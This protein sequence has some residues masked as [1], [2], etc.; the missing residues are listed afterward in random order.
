MLFLKRQLPLLI[1]FIFGMIGLLT[2][3]SPH[4][5]TE[6][7][8][9]ELVFW[10]RLVAA[11]ALLL[12]MYSLL[13]MHLG[14]VEKRAKG[15]GFSAVLLVGF[16]VTLGVGIYNEG[17]W[18]FGQRASHGM[19]NWIYDYIFKPA[20]ATMFSVLAFFIASAAYRTFRARTTM[21]ALLLIAALIVMVGQVPIGDMISS[22]LP[23]LSS[24][25]MEV[26]NAAVKR[27]IFM[28]VALGVVA[29]SLR[30]IFGVERAYLGGE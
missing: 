4:Q 28:G 25:L 7:V 1:A 2:G 9:T 29:T 16:F 18:L 27:G 3:Y 24:W 26:P 6:D 14:R 12:G 8:Y 19:L 30:I 21:A 15:F 10:D 17:D 22:K 5:V 20:G 23:M 11:F 13:K